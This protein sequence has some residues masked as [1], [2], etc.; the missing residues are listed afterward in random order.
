MKKIF[1]CKFCGSTLKKD[2]IALNQKLIHRDLK[3][4]MCLK[5]LAEDFNCTVEDLQN[6]IEQFKEEGCTLFL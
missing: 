2:W 3:E 4:F 6:K 1:K 5:C